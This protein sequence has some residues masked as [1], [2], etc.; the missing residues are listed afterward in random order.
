VEW[1]VKLNTFALVASAAAI[2]LGGFLATGL[3]LT[4]N[5][6]E[7]ELSTPVLQAF[8]FLMQPGYVVEG[9]R[10]QLF[11]LAESKS[12]NFVSMGVISTLFWAVGLG[13]L[14]WIGEKVIANRRSHGAAGRA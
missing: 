7:L 2:P 8:F 9:M 12:V 4:S 5:G 14:A 1:T 6:R 13:F 11:G 3:W 10:Q